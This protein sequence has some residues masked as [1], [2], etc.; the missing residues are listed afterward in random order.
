V[1]VGTALKTT[2]LFKYNAKLTAIKQALI[3][4]SD[5]KKFQNHWSKEQ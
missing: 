3:S 4:K 5:E 2:V 1:E